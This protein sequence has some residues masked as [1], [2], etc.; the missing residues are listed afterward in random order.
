MRCFTSCRKY[1]NGVQAISETP[2]KGEFSKDRFVS[3]E[4]IGG[5]RGRGWKDRKKTRGKKLSMGPSKWSSCYACC[6]TSE[7]CG[8]P[9][10]AP[11]ALTKKQPN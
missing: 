8:L 3:E 4:E 5:R 6:Q 7:M 9:P 10:N 11:Y 2:E 1:R